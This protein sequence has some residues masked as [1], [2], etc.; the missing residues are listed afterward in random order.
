MNKINPPFGSTRPETDVIERETHPGEKGRSFLVGYSGFVGG[1]LCRQMNFAAL[2][3]SR[4]ISEIRG[5]SC[6]LLVFAGAR[7]EKWRANV[8]PD[9]DLAGIDAAW[10]NVRHVTARHVLLISTVDV[11]AR[12]VGVDE[13]SDPDALPNHPYGRHRLLLEE[14]FKKHFPSLT[15]VRLPG[16]FGPGLKKNVIF[17]LLNG[18][19]LDH[20]NPESSFQYYP[21]KQLGP[22]LGRIMRARLRLVHLATEPISTADIHARFFANK[23]IGA[24]AVDAA[25]YDVRTRHADLFDATGPYIHSRDVIFRELAEFLAA[26]SSQ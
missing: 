10:D 22:D 9:I 14:R 19:N 23:G 2:Y 16:L 6:D 12:P 21:L 3:N 17:D 15:I 25:S 20:I 18:N 5:R 26:G 4:N 13:T 8:E 7:A 1:I 11:F 24:N